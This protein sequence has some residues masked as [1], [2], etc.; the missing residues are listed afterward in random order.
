MGLKYQGWG[1]FIGLLT[2]SVP[3]EALEVTIT[4][5]NPRLGDTVSVIMET[6]PDAE[7]PEV[8]WG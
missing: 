3:V 1:M 2:V 5:D 4:P 7:K 8:S 6:N